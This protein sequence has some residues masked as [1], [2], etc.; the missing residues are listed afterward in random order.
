MLRV[1]Y[2]DL[3]MNRWGLLFNWAVFGAL[4]SYQA[5]QPDA[6]APVFAVFA[7][8]MCAFAPVTLLVHEDKSKCAALTCSLPVTRRTIVAARYALTGLLT[9]VGLGGVTALVLVL[10]FSHLTAHELL[11]PGVFLSA[12]TIGGV[13]CAFMLPFTIRFGLAGLLAFL[14]SAQVVGIVLFMTLII[15]RSSADKRL[16]GA[17]LQALRDARAGLG[18]PAFELAVVVALGLL[19]ALSFAVSVR[20]FERREL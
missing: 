18:S 10:P 4:L 3:V 9:V 16:V 13:I 19:V 15:S 17:V 14:V 2:H 5:A 20:L 8:L 1:L 6:R 7:S 11:T 12:L